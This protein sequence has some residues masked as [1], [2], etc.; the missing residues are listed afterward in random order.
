MDTSPSSF[1]TCLWSTP[2]SVGLPSETTE[3][4]VWFRS[5]KEKIA[6]LKSAWEKEKKLK[7]NIAYGRRTSHRES[8][9]FWHCKARFFK[10]SLTL[11]SSYIHLLSFRSLK[12][13]R[14]KY[15]CNS[16]TCVRLKKVLIELLFCDL[17]NS[18]WVLTG[19]E[20]GLGSLRP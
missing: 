13:K 1:C 20:M 14:L 5:M 9:Y 12:K 8:N 16:G 3:K 4:S 2:C 6:Q 11:S 15:I 18:P 10:P 17:Y 7:F 19:S